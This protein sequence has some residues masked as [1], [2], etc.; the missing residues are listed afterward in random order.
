MYSNDDTARHQ[1]R[2]CLLSTTL[3]RL[4]AHAYVYAVGV[5]FCFLSLSLTIL[6]I[7]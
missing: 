4:Q 7:Y 3:A 2:Y 5:L 6:P 1:Q